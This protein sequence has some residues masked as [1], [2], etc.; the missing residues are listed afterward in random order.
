MQSIVID[1]DGVHLPSDLL[2]LPAGRY[3]VELVEDISPL[4]SEEE[5]GL[6]A[7]LDNL[8]AGRTIPFSDLVQNIRRG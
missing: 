1:W 4:R 3:I 5:D 2:K 8:D 7:A 6:I